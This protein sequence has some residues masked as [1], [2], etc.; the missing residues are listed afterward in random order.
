MITVFSTDR[1]I[2][3]A[4]RAPNSWRANCRRYDRPSAP[5]SF[6]RIQSSRIAVIAPAS[7]GAA[8]LLRVHDRIHRLP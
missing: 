2:C 8:P 3:C 1:N 5:K 7:F 4:V 6:E